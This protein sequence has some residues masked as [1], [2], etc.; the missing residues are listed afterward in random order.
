MKT[1][2]EAKKQKVPKTKVG[3]LSGEDGLVECS[4]SPDGLSCRLVG[5]TLCCFLLGTERPGASTSQVKGVPCIGCEAISRDPHTV[6]LQSAGTS[7]TLTPDPARVL[8]RA[9]R[10]DQTFCCRQGPRHQASAFP[11][12]NHWQPG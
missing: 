3:E 6:C 2:I 12:V 1:E 9:D 4:N 8:M 7:Q 5:K 11:S 10:C